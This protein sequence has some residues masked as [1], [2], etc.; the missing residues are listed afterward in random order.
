[1]RHRSRFLALL[2]ALLANGSLFMAG[3]VSGPAPVLAG[4][5]VLRSEN[6]A[7]LTG[8]RV[9][10]LTNLAA[11]TRDDELTVDVV[12]AAPGLQLVSLFAPEH[13]LSTTEDDSVAS[14]RDAR[15]G[16]MVHSLYGDTQRPTAAMLQGLDV[17][18]ID[19]PDAGARFYTYMT[20]VAYVME[21]A[22]KSGVAVMVLD[23]PNPVNGVSIEGP[24]LEPGLASFV[25]YF[26]SMPVRHGLTLG[27]LARLFNA[28]RKLGADLTVI[29]ARGWTRE[30]WFDE[31]G[32][33]WHNPS[34]NIRNLKAAALYPG[35]G[36]IEWSNISVGRGTDAPFEQIGAPWIDGRRLA[37]ALNERRVPGVTFSAT[38][39]TPDSSVYARQLCYGVA[40]TITGRRALRPVRAGV[41]IAA[42]LWRQ[43]PDRFEFGKTAQLLGSTQA[44]D[45]LKNGE[46]PAVI[47]ALWTG[48]EAR[49][50]TLRARY[51]LY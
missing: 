20:T 18:L 16:L 31:T 2:T 51:V 22:A 42:A 7:R 35:I 33:P 5:D 13:G 21:E 50:R 49:W 23:R 36:A 27:E 1:M 26:P 47:A 30:M 48:D 3:Q 17:I 41:E 15:T 25:G 38:S 10:L 12:R 4:I 34:P 46:D 6:F 40:V 45:R 11:H 28:E 19:L 32:L 44:V 9:A 37:L 8:R 43:H 24:A 29:A 39:F 14:T